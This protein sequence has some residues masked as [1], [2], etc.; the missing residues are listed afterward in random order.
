[1]GTGNKF[2]PELLEIM[3][4]SKTEYDPIA[5]VLRQKLR[6]E[7]NLDKIMVVASKERPL[8][9]NSQTHSP[10]SNAFVPNTAGIIAASYIFNQALKDIIKE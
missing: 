4:L 9:V 6:K 8:K 7:Y 10:S 1:M 5:R 3:P 2:H